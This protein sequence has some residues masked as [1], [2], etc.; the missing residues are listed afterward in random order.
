VRATSLS[1]AISYGGRIEPGQ[2]F[3]IGERLYRV[4][5]VTYSGAGAT[6]TITIRPPLREAV[7]NGS[8]LEFDFPVCRMRLASDTEMDLSLDQRRLGAPS[9]SFVED[10]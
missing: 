4:K 2:H 5:S 6:A 8:R 3:S 7:P 9:A 10:L 1:I